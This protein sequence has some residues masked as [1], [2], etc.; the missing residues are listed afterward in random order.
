MPQGKKEKDCELVSHEAS[1]SNK[2]N[3]RKGSGV[4]S[5]NNVSCAKKKR[6][7]LLMDFLCLCICVIRNPVTPVDES[8]QCD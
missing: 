8:E 7:K 6:K 3:V 5:A 1:L 4:K 2:I